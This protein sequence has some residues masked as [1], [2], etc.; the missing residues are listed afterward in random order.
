M[1]GII[2]YGAYLPRYRLQRKAIARAM[3]WISPATYTLASGEKA[4]ANYDE[5]TVTLAVAAARNALWRTEHGNVGGLFVASTTF[6]YGERQNGVIIREALSLP[7]TS[8]CLDGAGTPRAGTT[9]LGA[10]LDAVRSGQEGSAL[11]V[12]ADCRRAQPGT[13]D[14]YLFG[15]GAAAVV[16]GAEQVL[17]EFRGRY[18]LSFDFVDRLRAAEKPWSRLWEE[19]WIR[20]EGYL[21]LIPRAIAGYLEKSGAPLERFAGVVYPA[22]RIQDHAGIAGRLGLRP[23]QAAEPLL[24]TIGDTG[25][26][27]P[28]LML[29]RA[30]E[31]AAPGDHLLVV[32]FGSGVDVLHFEVSPLIDRFRPRWSFDALLD[33][34]AP[35]QPYEKYLTFRDLIPAA[36]GMRG[37]FHSE[38]PLSLLWRHR[39]TILGLEGSRC[40]ACGTVQFPPQ[41][42]CAVA[43]CGAQDRMDPYPFADQPCRI[44]SY[45]ADQLAFSYDPPQIYGIVDFPHG[46]RMMLDFTDCTLEE[47]AVDM[48][49]E[50]HLRRKFYD[51][52]RGVHAYFWKAVPQPDTAA[53]GDAP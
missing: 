1:A 21:S 41:R 10:A 15:D 46:G 11:V 38:T 39:R 16:V 28:L 24:L 34:K 4:V 17:A 9:V 20:S 53:E 18:G 49:A 47:V 7:E 45:T 29:C 35:L 5:D 44:F 2:S 26:A 50:L 13:T 32:G 22:A 30:L 52:Q 40:R 42:I 31:R 48:A 8:F 19:R 27:H 14:E 36:T 6:P 43:D 12:A 23:E 33:R 25:A 37:E 51:H 3:G